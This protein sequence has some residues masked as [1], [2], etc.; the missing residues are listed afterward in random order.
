MEPVKGV[1]K[2]I[3]TKCAPIVV[4]SDG[5]RGFG[6]ALGRYMLPV[7][8][9]IAAKDWIQPA[10]KGWSK[11]FRFSP[12]FP[13]MVHLEKHYHM[14]TFLDAALI[15]RDYGTDVFAKEE[16]LYRCNIVWKAA[17]VK[18]IFYSGMFYG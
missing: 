10:D 6:D 5:H 11:T 14:T 13:K 2:L 4:H 16:M 3:K 15:L 18:H 12:N 1:H 8:E 7:D 17:N 9:H